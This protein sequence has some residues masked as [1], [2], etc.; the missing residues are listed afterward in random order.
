MCG[1][2]VGAFSTERLLSELHG[3]GNLDMPVDVESFALPL[4]SKPN[5]NVAPTQMVPV[6][7]SQQGTIYCRM[8]RWGISPQWT[9]TGARSTLLI[10]ARSET[11]HEKR[12]FKGL[13]AGHRCVVPMNGFY[14]WQRNDSGSKTPYFVHRADDHL[15]LT[16]GL[17]TEPSASDDPGSFCV[18]T[19]QSPHEM[20]FIHD[21]CPL[22]MD[23]S[24]A[25][26]WLV[27]GL[28]PMELLGARNLPV[29]TSHIVS[30]LVNSVRNNG[31]LLMEPTRGD[32]ST[33]QTLF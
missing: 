8:F 12:S 23:V 5:F 26:D 14:E 9:K 22:Q 29:L 6:L 20:S 18:L 7:L 25:I 2:F 15:M 32:D 3:N 31:P 19:R 33:D 24:G 21:R 10:N 30:R 16:A 27:E 28:E 1:R 13:L 17:W 11:V 4:G